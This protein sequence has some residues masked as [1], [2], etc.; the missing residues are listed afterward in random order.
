MAVIVD[1]TIQYYDENAREFISRTLNSDMSNI[2][3]RFQQFLPEKATILDVGCG[4]GRD[5]RY[6][7][8]N[9]Y[10]VSSFDAS[11]KLCLEASKI[12]GV[13]VTNA[14]F[15][16]FSTTEKFDG[17]WACASLLHVARARQIRMINKFLRFLKK[18]G[19]FYASWRYGDGE[20]IE[21]GKYYCNL[22]PSWFEENMTQIEGRI[23]ECWKST[24]RRQNNQKVEWVNVIFC[25]KE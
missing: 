4:S 18:S 19:V 21:E 3:K 11:K 25:I 10:S 24:E 22:S 16:S 20:A 12:L 14:T 5:S 6:F 1:S 9:G 7:L 23:L 8:N 15:D 17:I 2:Y 13:P